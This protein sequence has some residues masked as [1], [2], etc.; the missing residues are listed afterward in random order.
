MVLIIGLNTIDPLFRLLGADE[1]ILPFIHRYMQIYYWG[2][3]F[4]V[5]PM[6]ANSVLRASGDA[7]RPAMIMTT[8][9]VLNVIIDPVLIF[10]LFGFPRMEI[11]GAAL[12]GVIVQRHHHV[13]L[14]LLRG[15]P[16]A[17]GGLRQAGPGT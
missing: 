1:E 15:V 3:I 12:G 2:G 10:G 8:A 5:A 4:L 7:K 14:G 17:A 6:I 16:G 11:E 9:A 13:R